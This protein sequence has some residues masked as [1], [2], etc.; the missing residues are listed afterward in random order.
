M[1]R[2]LKAELEVGVAV[3]VAG[4]GRASLGQHRRRPL[5]LCRR[6]LWA[7]QQATSLWMFSWLTPSGPEGAG[8]RGCGS[9]DS[10]GATQPALGHTAYCARAH[11]GRVKNIPP[12]FRGALA[13]GA[14]S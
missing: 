4:V 10:K 6:K 12:H 9:L 1:P 11:V 7:F 5:C 2:P 13:P 8:G 14:R 3:A